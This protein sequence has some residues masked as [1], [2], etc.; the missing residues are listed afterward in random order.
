MFIYIYIYIYVG[1]ETTLA[2]SAQ[3]C[4]GRAK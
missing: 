4:G 3:C 1:V 2:K